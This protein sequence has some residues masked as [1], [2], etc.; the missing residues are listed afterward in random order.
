VKHLDGSAGQFPR[1][2]EDINNLRFIVPNTK[3]YQNLKLTNMCLFVTNE[4]GKKTQWIGQIDDLSNNDETSKTMFL[5][6]ANR[7]LEST[8]TDWNADIKVGV[9]EGIHL[10]RLQ[11]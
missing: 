8:R 9:Y 6:S 7:R 4:K 2:K 1:K 3:M 5:L 11:C 10:P